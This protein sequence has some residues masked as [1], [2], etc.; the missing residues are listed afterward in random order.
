MTAH[1]YP[2]PDSLARTAG[3]MGMRVVQVPPRSLDVLV[4]DLLLPATA[5]PSTPREDRLGHHCGLLCALLSAH[6]VALLWRED[7]QTVFSVFPGDTGGI[8]RRASGTI[9]VA[10]VPLQMMAS[11]TMG[12]LIEQPS[13][14]QHIDLSLRRLLGDHPALLLPLAMDDAITGVLLL[15]LGHLPPDGEIVLALTLVRQA[16]ATGGAQVATMGRPEHSGATPSDVLPIWPPRARELRVS[17]AATFSPRELQIAQLLAAGLRN[18]QIA[19][20]LRIS[21]HT[22][23]FHLRRMFEKLGVESRTELLLRIVE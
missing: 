16:A 7:T 20:R 22:V 19:T 17:T 15:N 9:A 11:M 1:P 3:S 18:K 21:E 14:N 6:G 8:S 13:G 12:V 2:S 5:D 4:A 23:K 10:A